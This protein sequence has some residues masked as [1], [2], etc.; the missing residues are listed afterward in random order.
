[1]KLYVFTII[2]AFLAV[3]ANAQ[4][5]SGRLTLNGKSE[6]NINMETNSVVNLF[7]Q[8]KEGKYRIG[9]NFKGDNLVKNLYKEE[10][11]F[12]E[13]TTVVKKNGKTVSKITREQPMPYFPGEM[14]LPAEAFDFITG[15]AF[16]AEEEMQATVIPK[17][18]T[19]ILDE[20][21]YT[22]ELYANPKGVE[23]RV[24]PAT[25]NF[26]LRKRPGR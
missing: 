20:G 18:T 25:F 1:M 12:F 22:V 6:T 8:F 4:R 23:G 5:V 21:N 13:F 11:V 14:R 19:G 9:F 10:I 2:F 17:E 24:S 3:A 16:A 7:K 26:I 15:L